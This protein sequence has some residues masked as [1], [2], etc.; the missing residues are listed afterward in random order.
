MGIITAAI[1][2]KLTKSFNPF[3]LEVIDDSHKHAGHAGAA[4]H[5]AEHGAG[6]SHFR[7]IIVS[8]AFQSLS[9]LERHRAVMDVLSDEIPRIHALQLDARAD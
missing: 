8:D 9:R 4:T 6:E 5:A 1:K 3:H 2:E 7:V